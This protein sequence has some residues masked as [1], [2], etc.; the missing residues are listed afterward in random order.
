MNITK[1]ILIFYFILLLCLLISSLGI[2][3]IDNN[4]GIFLIGLSLFIVPLLAFMTILFSLFK[5]AKK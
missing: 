5:K 4:K 3:I 1:Q 2:W